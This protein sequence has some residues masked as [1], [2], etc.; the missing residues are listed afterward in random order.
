MKAPSNTCTLQVRLQP[1]RDCGR[2]R[3]HRE[4]ANE[5]IEGKLQVHLI[6]IEWTHQFTDDLLLVSS[7]LILLLLGNPPTNGQQLGIDL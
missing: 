7:N 4:L 1:L 2:L 6:L 5:A 3:P